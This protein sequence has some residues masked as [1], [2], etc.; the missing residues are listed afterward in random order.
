MAQTLLPFSDTWPVPQLLLFII[1]HLQ[2]YL[3]WSL[4][5]EILRNS[6]ILLGL[7]ITGVFKYYSVYHIDE[8]GSSPK[9]HLITGHT[10]PFELYRD[11]KNIGIS[12]R[13][14]SEN[15]RKQVDAE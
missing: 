8:Q 6:E 14:L 12:R 11:L 3:H 1:G 15:I 10:K 7:H 13:L 4:R 5:T 9:T 2:G